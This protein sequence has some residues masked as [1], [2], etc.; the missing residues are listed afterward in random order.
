MSDL[1]LAL[2]LTR[3]VVG[4][5]AAVVFKCFLRSRS[6]QVLLAGAPECVALLFLKLSNRA[7]LSKSVSTRKLFGSNSACP[8]R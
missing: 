7:H 2:N 8:L 4:G 3:L 1:K 6:P 5:V